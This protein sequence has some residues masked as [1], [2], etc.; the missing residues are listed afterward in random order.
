MI[1]YKVTQKSVNLKQ[2]FVLTG[3]FGIKPASQFVELY[4]SVVSCALNTEDLISNNV[5]K[6]NKW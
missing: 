4:H 6:Y 2:S 3:M 1:K 5:C